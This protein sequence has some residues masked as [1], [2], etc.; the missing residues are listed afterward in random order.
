MAEWIA[1]LIVVSLVTIFLHKRSM[2]TDETFQEPEILPETT[3]EEIPEV[4]EEILIEEPTPRELLYE[5]SK[6]SLGM[7]LTP[8][9]EIPD[10]VACVAQIQEVLRRTFGT[11]VGKGA[12]LYNTRAFL[13]ALVEDSSFLRVDEPL[14]GDIVVC[15]TGTSVKPNSG[16]VYGH[17]GI[18]GKT[19]WMSNSSHNGLW[20]ANYTK[21]SW[22]AYFHTKGGY[23]VHYF[24]KVV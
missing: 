13:N 23:P 16:V 18:V 22:I 7:D 11:Y 2:T 14:Y 21:D 12:A 24:R 17:C 5:V 9:D 20:E 4:V 1:A 10:S 19:H 8:K 3:P 15:A 6:A